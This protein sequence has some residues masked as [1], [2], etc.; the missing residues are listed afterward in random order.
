VAE[1][2]GPCNQD[3][4]HQE[5]NHDRAPPSNR[6]GESD[7]EVQNLG[8]LSATKRQDPPIEA[9]L[10][11]LPGPPKTVQSFESGEAW[12]SR[13][14]RWVELHPTLA[15]PDPRFDPGVGVRFADQ[16]FTP[17]SQYGSAAVSNHH[18]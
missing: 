9:G 7:E 8:L 16:G 18:P 10:D 11:A 6:I 4:R 2:C 12:H 13:R 17:V 14:R 1:G 15:R 3:G 5:D